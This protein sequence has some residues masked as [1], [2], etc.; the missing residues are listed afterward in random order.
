MKAHI[1]WLREK[2]AG[3]IRTTL[4]AAERRVRAAPKALEAGLQKRP[5]GAA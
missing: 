2:K 1:N 5:S 3:T 4:V